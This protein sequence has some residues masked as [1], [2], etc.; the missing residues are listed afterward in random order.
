MKTTKMKI[1][2]HK[3]ESIFNAIQE[4]DNTGGAPIR[5]SYALA[6]L[7]IQINPNLEAI[8]KAKDKLVK[9]YAPESGALSPSHAQYKNAMA[10]IQPVFE[11]EIEVSI[12]EIQ[13]EDLFKL[14][15]Q[16]KVSSLV[17]LMPFIS[18]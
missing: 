11:D 8:R 12:P 16:V 9:K 15:K 18:K 17:A 2:N 3:L 5:I 13:E 4:I 14:E 6:K 1:K 10:E 7:S